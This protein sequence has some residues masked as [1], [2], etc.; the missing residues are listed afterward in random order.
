MA[1]YKG[2]LLVVDLSDNK[3]NFLN[4][5]LTLRG[6]GSL[7]SA[8]GDARGITADDDY[9]YVIDNTTNEIFRYTVNL[10]T[11]ALTLVS[12]WATSR[13]A[14]GIGILG[15]NLHVINTVRAV[16]RYNKSTG[17]QGTVALNIPSSIDGCLLYTSPSPRDRQKSRMPSSA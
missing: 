9:I 12:R 5:D 11:F 3:V 4:D 1:V 8:N 2:I 15:N 10:T 17:V 6:E 14:R 16:W 13:G 7:H